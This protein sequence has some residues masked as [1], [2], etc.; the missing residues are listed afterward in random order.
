MQL[1]NTLD[2]RSS[3]AM[4]ALAAVALIFFARYAEAILLPVA[5]ALVL[6]FLLS[7]LVRGMRR[8]GVPDALGAAVVVGGFVLAVSIWRRC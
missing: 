7:P 2:V 1:S 3:R 5:V 4:Q 8:H 6:T